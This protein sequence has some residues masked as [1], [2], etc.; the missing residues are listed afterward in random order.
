[1]KVSLE[2][3]DD[4]GAGG[5]YRRA[6]AELV[7][8]RAHRP[9][10][11]V[12]HAKHRRDIFHHSDVQSAH[13]LR[14]L[15]A[16]QGEKIHH[17]AGMAPGAQRLQHG[18]A[19]GIMAAAGI[20]RENQNMHGFASFLGN[21]L[22]LSRLCKGRRVPALEPGKQKQNPPTAVITAIISENW[23]KHK[24]GRQNSPRFPALRRAE[25]RRPSG[26]RPFS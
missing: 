16:G 20:A 7:L 11:T 3:R 8:R 2:P 19:C 25:G 12:G 10:H 23:V 6:H 24:G 15:F 22:S 18:G 13:P 17:L 1:M 14:H 26:P 4:L 9:A 21:C 5:V